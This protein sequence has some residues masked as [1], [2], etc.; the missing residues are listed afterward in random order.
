MKVPAFE[1]V[2][3]TQGLGHDTLGE[4]CILKHDA[5]NLIW[6]DLEMTGLHPEHHSILEIAVVVTDAH[7]NVIAE[8]PDLVIHQDEE[9]LRRMDAF[10]RDMHTRSGLLEQVKH[11]TCTEAQAEQE[12]LAFLKQHVPEK[13]S[14]LCGNSICMDRRFL[15]QYMPTLETYFHYRHLDVSTLKVLAS[16]WAPDIFQQI[17]K[18]NTHRALDDV[19]ESIDELRFYRTHL[20]QV[21]EAF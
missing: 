18:E 15:Y 12:V 2:R 13:V 6:L 5:S 21:G 10:V 11:S 8:G 3:R 20:M 9:A 16:L 4:D 1:N 7:L 19:Y 17:E 14:P